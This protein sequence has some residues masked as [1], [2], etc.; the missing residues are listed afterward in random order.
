MLACALILPAIL[1]ARTAVAQEIDIDFG[2]GSLLE[3]LDTVSTSV[4]KTPDSEPLNI[5]VDSPEA[6]RIIKIPP[7][8][9]TRTSPD[10]AVEIV[11]LLARGGSVHVEHVDDARIVQLRADGPRPEAPESPRLII[12][13]LRSLLPDRLDA[14]ERQAKLQGI[15]SALE[16]ALE[17]SEPP[18]EGERAGRA[19]LKFHVDTNLLFVRGTEEQHDIVTEVL[20]HL[21]VTKHDS[22]RQTTEDLE[23]ETEA[24]RKE[25][26]R[27]HME[28]SQLKNALKEKE[29]SS[30]SEPAEKSDSSAPR[31]EAEAGETAP[32]PRGR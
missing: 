13:S 3:Y 2:G 23:R 32:L 16:T 14:E 28:I 21:E 6:A 12:H 24:L 7:V 4:N 18:K 25:I 5:V 19:Q 8:R 11:T 26:A 9:L 22:S 17:L 15:L 10:T 31:P 29:K 30:T 20:S 1:A 27:L